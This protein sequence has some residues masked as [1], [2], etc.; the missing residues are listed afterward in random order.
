MVPWK[1]AMIAASD[2]VAHD[3]LCGKAGDML[4]DVPAAGSVSSPVSSMKS[5]PYIL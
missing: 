3:A 2:A 1:A 5:G 4:E